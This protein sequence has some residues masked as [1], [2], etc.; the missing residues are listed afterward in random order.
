MSVEGDINRHH[1]DVIDSLVDALVKEKMVPSMNSRGVYYLKDDAAFGLV[2]KLK[3]DGVDVVDSDTELASSIYG[4][5]NKT[6]LK[7]VGYGMLNATLPRAVAAELTPWEALYSYAGIWEGKSTNYTPKQFR[8]D[9][10]KHRTLYQIVRQL[11][12][13][14]MERI[15]Y[16][17]NREY[18]GGKYKNYISSVPHEREIR[19][20]MVEPRIRSIHDLPK[21]L[22]KGQLKLF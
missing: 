21:P 14:G 2:R 22:P 7:Q 12:F 9:Q 13:N 20:R 18:E 6:P 3:S 19:D 11:V 15:R 16:V 17:H 5:I 1:F 8:R 4:A 10:L